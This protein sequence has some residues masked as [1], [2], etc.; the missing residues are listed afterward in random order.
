MS[1]DTNEKKS[2]P[3]GPETQGQRWAKYGSNV[4]LMSALA[5]ALFVLITY[6][7]QANARRLDT[8]AQGVNS[9]KPQTLNVIHGLGSDVKIVSLYP[10]VEQP[11]DQSSPGEHPIDRAQFVSD[12]LDNYRRSS[13]RISVEAIDPAD[14]AKIDA[15]VADLDQRYGK[16]IKG[17]KDFLD[18]YQK[19][20]YPQISKLIASE[21]SKIGG[22]INEDSEKIGPQ[23]RGTFEQLGKLLDSNKKQLNRRLQDRRPDYHGLTNSIRETLAQ[24]SKTEQSMVGFF[25]AHKSDPD[26]SETIKQY[27]A[28][29]AP[30]QLEIKNI[31]DAQIVKIDKLG[32]LK[33]DDLQRA[34]NVKDP[35][36]VLGPTD[37]RV[38]SF[39]QVWPDSKSIKQIAEGK[40]QRS[41]AGEQQISTAIISLTATKK[42]KVVFL[43]PGGGPL[44]NPG[45]PFQ[46]GGP[47]SEFAERL[48]EYNFEVLEKD[49]SGQSQ[50]NPEQQ[51]QAPE[52]GWEQLNDAVWILLDA[53]GPQQ[54]GE[55]IAPRLAAHLGHGGSALILAWPQGDNLEM[56]LRDW[57][58]E[59]HTDMI[60]VHEQIPAAANSSGSDFIQQALRQ[61]FIWDLK[62]Y[63]DAALAEPLKN[64]DS[65]WV[66]LTPVKSHEVSG[67]KTTQL[68]P[69]PDAPQAPKSWGKKDFTS[70]QDGT[71]PKFQPD[72]GDI[73]G[74]LFGGAAVEKQNGGR[75]VVLGCGMFAT[76]TFLLQLFDQDIARNEGRLVSRFPGNGEMAT[77][78]VFWCSKM[79]SMIALS[80]AALQVSRISNMSP[81]TLGFWRVGM[82][83]VGLPCL[84]LVGGLGMY[85]HR[86]D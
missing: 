83:L 25:A 66:E 31:A 41:F 78:S 34:M 71:P 50:M 84:V 49:I 13:S 58:V 9:L 15:L 54:N 16:D 40:A 45:S 42:P 35:I 75:L 47:F 65:L 68:L 73:P 46:E 22:G 14:K 72:K 82:L 26:A 23:I 8:T 12:L 62:S 21:Q 20:A 11:D 32:E 29:G 17:Y 61:S 59:L 76:N 44:T 28:A 37:W 57:G 52:P 3:P 39:D 74:P 43:R 2:P 24:V 60:T 79:D 51:Q 77:N 18:S 69:I 55:P 7:A 33:V 30:A 6:I 70:L 67:Y 4:V 64:L 80:P 85:F 56:A 53:G 27:M 38:L 36:L 10:K 5:I 1:A 86:R 48:R 81:V 19:D 63:G